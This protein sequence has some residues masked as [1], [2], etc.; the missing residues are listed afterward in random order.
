MAK[1]RSE[2]TDY[3]KA[4]RDAYNTNSEATKDLSR[5]IRDPSVTE[6]D[7]RQMLAKR[8]KASRDLPEKTKEYYQS[9]DETGYKHSGLPSGEED[10]SLD[11]LS[12]SPTTDEEGNMKY[13]KGG[14]VKKKKMAGGGMV[15]GAGC[16]TKGKGKMR[17]F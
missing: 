16:A 6:A 3:T 1:M 4:Q 15:R 9:G 10:Y 14:M 17:M 2:I 13:R 12:R 11:R 8:Q 7:F 5:E